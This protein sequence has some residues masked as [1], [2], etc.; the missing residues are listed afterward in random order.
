[1]GK[2]RSELCVCYGIAAGERLSERWSGYLRLE[3]EISAR[4][5]FIA[6]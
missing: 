3:G 5:G 6:G 1:M 4:F 2:R